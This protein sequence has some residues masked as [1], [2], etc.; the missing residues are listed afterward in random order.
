M[1][2]K[3]TDRLEEG[4]KMASTYQMLPGRQINSPFYLFWT[5]QIGTPPEIQ[6]PDPH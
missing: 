4:A 2:F 3:K 5:V 6:Y 1:H